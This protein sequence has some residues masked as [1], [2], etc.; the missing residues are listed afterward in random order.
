MTCSRRWRSGG[1][2]TQAA[3]PRRN[4]RMAEATGSRAG[5]GGPLRSVAIVMLTAVGD[6]VHVLPVVNSLRAAHPGVRITWIV[7]PGPGGLVAGHP[8]VD[9]FILFDRKK[10]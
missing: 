3:V 7:Q 8:A 6:V 9:E 4:G 2:S 1:T 5:S 10:G